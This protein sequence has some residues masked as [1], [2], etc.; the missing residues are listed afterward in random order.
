MSSDFFKEKNYNNEKVKNIGKKHRKR[1]NLNS[2]HD[3]LPGVLS[4]IL[5][6][7]IML[8]F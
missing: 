8:L 2:N 3:K 7:T 1:T 4:V 5:L 6:L